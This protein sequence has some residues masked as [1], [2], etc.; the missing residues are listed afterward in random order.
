[1]IEKAFVDA[2]DEGT[3]MQE[4]TTKYSQITKEFNP[5]NYEL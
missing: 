1:M 4:M 2:P 3:F 5:R